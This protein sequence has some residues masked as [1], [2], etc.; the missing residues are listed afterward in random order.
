[1]PPSDLRVGVD[2]VEVDRFARAVERWPRLLERV[3]TAS[4]LRD[5]AGARNASERLAARFAAKEATFKA[6]RKGW[7]DLHY[8]DV[9]LRMEDGAPALRL[10][11]NAAALANGLQAAVSLS[12]T[13][14][15]A[16]A[17]VVMS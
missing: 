9:E 6:L 3:F 12:H 11:A 13:G 10:R 14:G 17:Q 15:M 1:M 4:E 8:R 5:C 2:L 7:P 16:I